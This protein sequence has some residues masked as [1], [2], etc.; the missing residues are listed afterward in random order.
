[1]SQIFNVNSK[2]PKPKENQLEILGIQLGS[3][4]I[5]LEIQQRPSG[6]GESTANTSSLDIY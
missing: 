1:M 4:G 2:G 5:L 6:P 3:L